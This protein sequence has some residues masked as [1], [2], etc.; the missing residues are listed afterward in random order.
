MDAEGR[1]RPELSCETHATTVGQGVADTGGQH[2]ILRLD[3]L[4]HCVFPATFRLKLV[5]ASNCAE[6]L[7]AL[8]DTLGQLRVSTHLHIF[9]DKFF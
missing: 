4:A 6:G 2:S 7:P 8:A 9:L 5:S 1:K 3:Y